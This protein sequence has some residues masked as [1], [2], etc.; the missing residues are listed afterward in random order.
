[1]ADENELREL[2]NQAITCEHPHVYGTVNLNRLREVLCLLVS[3]RRTCEKPSYIANLSDE[4]LNEE[5]KSFHGIVR[6]ISKE[7]V[8]CSSSQ[9]VS[10][11]LT[12]PSQEL[13]QQQVEENL[14]SPCRTL[15]LKD[16][17]QSC[18]LF[19][20]QNIVFEIE[21]VRRKVY[22]IDE[23]VAKLELKSPFGKCQ[24]TCTR[25]VLAV[26]ANTLE[27]NSSLAGEIFSPKPSKTDVSDVI[28]DVER[29][30]SFNDGEDLQTTC[31]VVLSEVA[32]GNSIPKTALFQPAGSVSKDFKSYKP[33]PTGVVVSVEQDKGGVN[34]QH[35]DE[36]SAFSVSSHDTER[37]EVVPKF[38]ELVATV[39]GVVERENMFL[40]RLTNI[41]KLMSAYIDELYIRLQ[42]EK[43]VASTTISDNIARQQNIVQNVQEESGM[44]IGLESVHQK[45]KRTESL[46]EANV[47]SIIDELQKDIRFLK[48]A[49][50]RLNIAAGGKINAEIKN[51]IQCISCNCAAAM[52]IHEELIPTPIPLHTRRC[53]KPILRQ[54]LHWLERE[55]KYSTIAPVSMQPYYQL[56][57]KK[58]IESS[59]YESVNSLASSCLDRWR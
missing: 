48:I 58:K 3:A 19:S 16:V 11:A 5:T 59:A 53:V 42:D 40:E 14:N 28:F 7:E 33:F 44:S 36:E 41:E 15:S 35:I 13:D 25:D 38:D 56:L 18:T 37:N 49:F 9:N 2:I 30:V 52:E 32:R 46:L 47:R 24:C 29:G 4:S 50:K 20:L 43:C 6:E 34:G 51:H 23:R 17:E 12:S 22:E 45:P 26:D 27:S 10:N 55:L 57:K 39:D 31:E 1:M 21:Q 8:A 54:Q